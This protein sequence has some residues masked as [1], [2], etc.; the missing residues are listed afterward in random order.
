MDMKLTMITDENAEFFR[1][2][3]GERFRERKDNEVFTGVIDDRKEPVAA[4]IFLEEGDE[5][6]LDLIAVVDGRRRQG[7]GSFLIREMKEAALG[8]GFGTISLVMYRNEKS[9]EENGFWE[10]L[11]RNGFQIQETETKRRVYDLSGVMEL[12]PFSETPIK[13]PFRI[14]SCFELTEEERESLKNLEGVTDGAGEKE[15]ENNRYGG[16]VL[17]RNEVRAMLVCKPE[18][19]GVLI[20]S[21]LGTGEGLKHFPWLF[22]NARELIRQ[23]GMEFDKLYIDTA[24]KKT[25]DYE[26]LFLRR[27]GIEASEEFTGFAATLHI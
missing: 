10:F 5:L 22:D 25:A 4:A 14:K 6:L 15:L 24:G 3:I 17:E 21:I 26:D 19:D 11:A 2:V 13:R 1:N 18:W 9:P 27:R 16:V 20:S 8:A 7:V 23:E 12:P